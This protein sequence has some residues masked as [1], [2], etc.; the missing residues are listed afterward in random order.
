MYSKP[1][2]GNITFSMGAGSHCEFLVFPS[3]KHGGFFFGESGHTSELLYQILASY[4]I[5]G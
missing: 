5:F 2:F 4:Y 1:I 3:Q